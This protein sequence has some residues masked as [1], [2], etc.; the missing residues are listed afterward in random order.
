MVYKGGKPYIYDGLQPKAPRVP[1][2]FRS[3]AP[4]AS[5]DTSQDKPMP[6]K[7]PAPKGVG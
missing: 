2:G 5:P 3:D 6:E 7:A 4:E 1:H